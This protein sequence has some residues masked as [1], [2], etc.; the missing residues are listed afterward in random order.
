MRA[1]LSGMQ[2]TPPGRIKHAA[3]AN[4]G[5]RS[6]VTH[7]DS[8][9]PAAWPSLSNAGGGVATLRM[10]PYLL[11]LVLLYPLLHGMALIWCHAEPL[12]AGDGRVAVRP[13][14]SV[15]T[16]DG[17]AIAL[18]KGRTSGESRDCGCKNDRF[19]GYSPWCWASHVRS[20]RVSAA[21]HVSVIC[22]L[23]RALRR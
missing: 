11:G 7:Q 4:R 15:I 3:P 19:H 5:G 8:A 18:S 9:V 14:P 2:R 10:P 21:H 12:C 17:A 13:L 23:W 16:K 20:Y 22:R 1:C 6:G